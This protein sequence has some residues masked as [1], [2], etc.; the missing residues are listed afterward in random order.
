MG[1]HAPRQPSTPDILPS[2]PGNLSFSLMTFQSLELKQQSP[3]GTRFLDLTNY[4]R[5]LSRKWAP[6]P[7]IADLW[8]T[9]SQGFWFYQFAFFRNWW[10]NIITFLKLSLF[11]LSTTFCL[12]CG[13]SPEQLIWNRYFS[14]LPEGF[15]GK[16]RHL[17]TLSWDPAQWE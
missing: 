1:F 12:G 10:R 17:L 5:F 11:S 2:S 4:S 9:R 14:L 15:I 3:R 13:F 6:S 8:V 7:W 16:T